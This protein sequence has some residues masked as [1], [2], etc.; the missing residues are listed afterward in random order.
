MQPNAHF[1]LNIQEVV[2]SQQRVFKI[3]KKRTLTEERQRIQGNARDGGDAELDVVWRKERPYYNL[4]QIFGNKPN[5]LQASTVRK[6]TIL[7]MQHCIM[8]EEPKLYFYKLLD[9]VNRSSSCQKY[10]LPPRQISWGKRATKINFLKDR[11]T[12]CLRFRSGN[13]VPPP[14][15]IHNLPPTFQDKRKLFILQRFVF[16]LGLL[17]RKA[18]VALTNISRPP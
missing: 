17:S 12:M 15:N 5:T 8:V 16:I 11:K 2:T 4:G 1:N 3:E 18:P 9:K 14:L 13:F 10:E 6:S 7:N